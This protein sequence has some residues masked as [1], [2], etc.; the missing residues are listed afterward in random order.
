MVCVE[1]KNFAKKEMLNRKKTEYR[2]LNTL[3]YDFQDVED[4]KGVFALQGKSHSI[5]E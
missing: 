5:L 2:L 1:V 3:E 4:F